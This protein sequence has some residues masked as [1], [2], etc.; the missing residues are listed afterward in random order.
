MVRI[1]RVGYVEQLQHAS[2]EADS[3]AFCGLPFCGHSC[4]ILGRRMAGNNYALLT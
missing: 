4:E 3:G 1:D 2:A